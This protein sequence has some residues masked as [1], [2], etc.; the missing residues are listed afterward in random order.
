MCLRHGRR[1]S[2]WVCAPASCHT[3]YGKSPPPPPAPPRHPATLPISQPHTHPH[4]HSSTQPPAQHPSSPRPHIRLPTPPHAAA[5]PHHQPTHP[6]PHPPTLRNTTWP[7][8]KELLPMARASCHSCRSPRVDRMGTWGARGVGVQARDWG[9]VVR[10][11]RWDGGLQQ[12]Q[13]RRCL[14]RAIAVELPCRPPPRPVCPHLGKAVR[15]CPS[16]QHHFHHSPPPRCFLCPPTP[17][18]VLPPCRA[19]HTRTPPLQT[20]T[21]HTAG[22]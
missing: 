22:L 5:H 3:S 15:Y 20:Q 8:A 12:Q 7:F 9:W 2:R 1:A 4:T 10:G 18:P 14:G 16:L 19:P 17:P 6:P 21:S 13:R 11:E